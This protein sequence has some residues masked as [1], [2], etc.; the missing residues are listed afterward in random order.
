MSDKEKD[1]AFDNLVASIVFVFMALMEFI[2][3]KRKKK[4]DK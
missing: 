4:G 1:K 2:K 3:Q